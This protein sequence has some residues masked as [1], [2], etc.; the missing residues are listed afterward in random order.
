MEHDRTFA[1]QDHEECCAISMAPSFDGEPQWLET[2]GIAVAQQQRR[3]TDEII[4]TIPV[5]SV[6]QFPEAGISN[7]VTHYHFL[8]VGQTI[9]QSLKAGG[10]GENLPPPYTGY[11]LELYR[12]F[13][14]VTV[15]MLIS[16]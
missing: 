10:L 4:L 13:D 6:Q 12:R 7:T 2:C 1:F 16:P 8:L 5:Y 11:R 14:N 9:L 15:R 3:E